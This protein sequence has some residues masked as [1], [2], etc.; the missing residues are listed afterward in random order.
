MRFKE[1]YITEEEIKIPKKPGKTEVS[2]LFGRFSPFTKGHLGIL[3]M[4]KQDSSLPIIVYLVKGKK[5]SLDKTKNPF[6]AKTQKMLIKKSAGNLIKDVKFAPDGFVPNVIALARK[7][8]YE[9]R[10]FY[11]GP[12]R[13][14]VYQA[15]IDKIPDKDKLKIDAKVRPI[16]VRIE[17]IS[18]TKVREAI[19][20]GD[21]KTFQKMTSGYDRKIFNLLKTKMK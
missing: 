15:M 16:K 14:K 6:D 13:E 8:G 2:I 5:S 19:Q 17:G 21:F 3:K 12:D 7:D 20:S 11:A 10:S 4:M 1:F 18:A 9:P